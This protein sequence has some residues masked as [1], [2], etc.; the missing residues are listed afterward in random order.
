M[1]RIFILSIATSAILAAGVSVDTSTGGSSKKATSTQSTSD[2]QSSESRSTSSNST[3]SNSK[4]K[5]TSSTEETANTKTSST[6]S[7]KSKT[8]SA[9]FSIGVKTPLTAIWQMPVEHMTFRQE[10]TSKAFNAMST[11]LSLIQN[12]GVIDLSDW[13]NKLS[14]ILAS[15]D[16]GTF[17]AGGGEK[18]HLWYFFYHPAALA[19]VGVPDGAKVDTMMS[20]TLTTFNGSRGYSAY[21]TEKLTESKMGQVKAC[22]P[23]LSGVA[24]DGSNITPETTLMLRYQGYVNG[25]TIIKEG[26]LTTLATTKGGEKFE[27]TTEP[28][29]LL[30]SENGRTTEEFTNDLI[31]E[32]IE[33]VLV[34]LSSDNYSVVWN[35]NKPRAITRK[36]VDSF[37][38]N[39]NLVFKD[40]GETLYSYTNSPEY[41]CTILQNAKKLQSEKGL[42]VS[43][44]ALKLKSMMPTKNADFTTCQQQPKIG[45]VMFDRKANIVFNRSIEI[46]A[47]SDET[48]SDAYAA[49]LQDAKTEKF[50]NAVQRAVAYLESKGYTTEAN[51]MRSMAVKS[52]TSKSFDKVQE[53]TFS[54]KTVSE[55]FE[56]LKK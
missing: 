48:V 36:I 40:A 35:N 52:T 33:N 18:R 42:S 56:A 31:R 46:N 41:Y 27:I 32:E 44:I 1:K 25:K 5:T 53:A 16:G 17:D 37:D 29:H 20:G 54:A 23:N 28:R 24:L 30:I 39:G 19:N 50:A 55:F 6:S 14:P 47:V 11:G 26:Q 12:E 49:M 8:S 9:S 43:E 2:K 4:T 13:N 51:A 21:C 38:A 7:T 15:R 34:S 22:Y 45:D 10:N 3:K